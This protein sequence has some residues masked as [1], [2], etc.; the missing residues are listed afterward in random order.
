MSLLVAITGWEAE[1]WHRRFRELAPDR[2]VFLHTGPY[3]AERIRYA[4]A[5]KAPHGLLKTLPNLEAIFSLGAGVDHLIAD[6][7][8]PDVPIVRIVDPDLTGRM[9][10]YVV[11]HVLMHHR[12]QR[13]YDT[14]QRARVWREHRQPAAREVR[15][16]IMG[17]GVLG[18]DAA[19]KLAHLGF[20][21]AGWSRNA[22]TV[23]GIVSFSGEAELDAFLE[24]TDILVVL[25][26]LTDG[27][28]GILDRDL[29]ERLAKDGELGGPILINAGRGGLQV[30]EDILAA[31]DDHTL[32]AATLDVFE[33]EP[34]A[35]SS[36]L[37]THPKV[38]VTPHN[39][40]VSQPQ[41]L[42]R[43]ILQQIAR[44][45]GGAAFENVVDRGAGY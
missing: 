23:P 8:L 41:A 28:R 39:A 38:T 26:P 35:P 21:V 20:D 34:L 13:L 19:E 24:R 18:R 22:K 29:F 1:V 36:R 25:L 5:W 32:A 6:P 11:L 14:Q 7:D 16:G 45:E 2:E 44:H 40:A 43:Y 4:C 27:T 33:R 31:L 37:W 3:P 12:R 30:E 42:T 9:S 17:L 10:E 15:V